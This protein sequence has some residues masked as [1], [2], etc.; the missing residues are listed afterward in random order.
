MFRPSSTARV[1][2]HPYTRLS[3]GTVFCTRR[4]WSYA[5]V[6]VVPFMEL[7]T[8]TPYKKAKAILSVAVDEH[9]GNLERKDTRFIPFE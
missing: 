1:Y 3:S 6:K 5:D 9:A 8:G 4:P 7:I 2:T